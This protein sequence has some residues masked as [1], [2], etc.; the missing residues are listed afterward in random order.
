ML[1]ELQPQDPLS[2][3]VTP[4]TDDVEAKQRANLSALRHLLAQIHDR[5]YVIADD[6]IYIANNCTALT[7]E[8]SVGKNKP[9][10]KKRKVDFNETAERK[11]KELTGILTTGHTWQVFK[12]AFDEDEMHD[13]AARM[14]IEYAGS[15]CLPVLPYARPS[16]QGQ[17]GS[18]A[19]AVIRV[20]EEDVAKVMAALVMTSMEIN[21]ENEDEQARVRARVS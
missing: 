17:T 9:A 16:A 3:I 6:I 21:A 5:V 14:R 18:G 8:H 2:V 7:T 15:I 1:V 12:F 11:I 10:A 19:E 4:I 20:K 13:P